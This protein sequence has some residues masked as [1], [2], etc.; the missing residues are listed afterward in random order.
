[1]PATRRLH[2]NV[3]QHVTG[4]LEQSLD[5]GERRE[6][7]AAIDDF[8]RGRAPLVVPLALLRHHVRRHDLAGL[9]AQTYLA[10]APAE[11]LLRNHV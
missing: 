11:L 7:H 10:P 2:V 1:L 4:H 6:L 3:L 8:Q 5:A 9:A